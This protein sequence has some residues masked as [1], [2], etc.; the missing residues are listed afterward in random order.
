[1]FS[2]KEIEALCFLYKEGRLS[3]SEEK[4]LRLVLEQ[5]PDLTRVAT[6][7]LALMDIEDMVFTTKE[8][9]NKKVWKW[10]F[11]SIAAAILIA[12]G[13]ALPI[14]IHYYRSADENFV[15][16]QNGE[17]ITGEEAQKLAEE[18]Q[19]EDMEM[20]R[21]I[22]KQQREMMKR[23]FASVNMDDFEF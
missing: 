14:T 10:T 13:V 21:Q 23:N 3:R 12:C 1:M 11:S 4:S 8:K 5:T 6:E 19:L 22:M 18:S 17:K 15:V 20:I 7:T 2:K 16:W 9:K